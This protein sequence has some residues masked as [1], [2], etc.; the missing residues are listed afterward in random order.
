VRSHT[1]SFT[2]ARL[3]A[4]MLALALLIAPLL[5]LATT[6]AHAATLGVSNT[7]DS[8]AGS[9]RQAIADAAPGDTITFELPNPSII[10]LNSEL[11]IAKNL[12]ISGPSAAALTI[13][14]NN[15]S[16]VFFI[17][18]GASGASSGPPATSLAVSISNLTIANG[19]AK[20]GDGGAA[21][22]AGGSGG[23]AGMGGAVFV[24]NS[25]LTL[26]G[27]TFSANQ[28]Q[29]GNGSGGGGSFFGAAGGG[30]VGGNGGGTNFPGGVG[31]SGGALGG[32]GGAGG[33]AGIYLPEGSNGGNGG[34]GGD[35]AGAGGGG[36]GDDCP[37]F[38]DC[39]GPG[40][41]G[42]N[43]GIGGFG[44]AG[45]GGGSS[46][47]D[48]SGSA[49]GGIGGAG[50]FGG[51]GGGGGGAQ[52]ISFDA[53]AR[54][55]GLG[56]SFGGNGGSSSDSDGGSGGG[57]AGLGG[58]IFIRAGSLTLAD[59]SFTSN[60][61]SGGSSAQNG[62][63]KG[64]AIFLLSPATATGCA[65]FS[66]N[67]A[68]N[69]AGSGT[70]TNDIYGASIPA[71]DSTPPVI[72]PN[73]SGTLGNNGWYISDVT[74]SWSVVDNESTISSQTGCTSS[75]VSSD[76]SGVTFTC[77][78]TSADGTASHS[79][80]VKRDTIAPALAPLVSPNPVVL[81]G[82][83]SVTANA[84][85]T[86]SGLASQS[87]GTLDTSSLGSKSVSCTA[88]DKAGNSA[89]AAASYQVIYPWSGFFQ[90]V[91]NLPTLN[92]VK[93]GQAVPVKFGLGGN[94]GLSILDSGYPISRQIACDGGAPADDIEQTVTAGS[95]SLSYDAA[96]GQY[97]YTWKTDKS[98]AGSCRQL[99]VRLVDGTDHIALFKFK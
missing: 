64:G 8:G 41:N 27:V 90:P 24:N 3:R 75:T 97:S 14:G 17:N 6:P 36:I 30:G 28:A 37:N 46:G 87:C 86:L 9:L 26:S 82:A 92:A 48:R 4:L 93:A 35:G 52:G 78:A 10:T 94:R 95:S 45:G 7:N 63:G 42:G 32:S 71:C 99:L 19:R 53:R 88:T 40:A 18:P 77:T 13:S 56:G 91:D 81:N 1:R 96:S 11:V 20:G 79:V 58:A 60:T 50:G 57:G 16:R 89:S 98:W 51:G 69:A 83:A 73:I 74:V 59:S 72:T 65:T 68:T 2:I 76:T 47:F 84:S 15:A 44:G 33:A 22:I 85:D 55:G 49:T 62:Q 25:N 12:T 31:G 61:A 67:S 34:T 5:S 70:D 29:G 21:N 54:A 39:T 23:A 43:G 66:G 80:T 38:P